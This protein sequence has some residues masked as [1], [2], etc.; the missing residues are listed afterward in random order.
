MK[1]I[2]RIKEKLP[3]ID[4][5][6]EKAKHVSLP[7]FHKVPI[8]HV[9]IF[10]FTEIKRDILPVRAKAIAFNLFLAI[11]PGLIFLFTLIPYIPIDGL[12]ASLV[13]LLNDVLPE[14]VFFF[15][16]ETIEDTVLNRR[17]SLLS[18]GILFTLFIASNGV[19][20]MIDS[21]NKSYDTFHDRNFITKR[22]VALKLTL[23]LSTL[24]FSSIVVI[25]LG[26]ELLHLILDTLGV[27]TDF[28]YIL[29]TTLR[30]LTILLLFFLGISTIYYYGP[31]VKKKWSF[32]SPGSTLATVLCILIS[33]GFSYFVNNFGGYNKL[34]GSIG[35]I[36]ALL[37][38][39][40][41]NALALLVGF[42]L[43][44]SIAYNRNLLEGEKE[45]FNLDRV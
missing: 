21:F 27:D 15:I 43:N 9:V 6:I 32:V 1:L 41:F 31:A 4:R 23:L 25:I 3:I 28:N 38:W 13:S 14:D 39:I 19:I 8:Y 12:Q 34:Y 22:W 11:F 7:G 17:A 29:F 33:L 24:L 42:E 36:I 40:Y 44:A 37:F 16:K 20:G 10:F 26:D 45:L 30:Y 18:V 5:L 35:T 2:D